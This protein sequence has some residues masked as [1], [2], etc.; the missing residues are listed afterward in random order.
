MVGGGLPRSIPAGTVDLS[1]H[2]PTVAHPPTRLPGPSTSHTANIRPLEHHARPLVQRTSI[3]S[4]WTHILLYHEHSSSHKTHTPSSTVF[5]IRRLLS[6]FLCIGIVQ[7]LL[8]SA[9]ISKLWQNLVFFN[10]GFNLVCHVDFELHKTCTFS[11]N[12]M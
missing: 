5:F 4:N 3:L 12:K 10:V 11:N 9:Y 6:T 1:T 7:F 8:T 2:G